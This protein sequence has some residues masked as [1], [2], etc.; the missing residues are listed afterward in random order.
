MSNRYYELVT[1]INDVEYLSTSDKGIFIELM[2]S[3]DEDILRIIMNTTHDDE[4]N[5]KLMYFL[6]TL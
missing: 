2:N 3:E 6:D 4:L 5:E 1:Y